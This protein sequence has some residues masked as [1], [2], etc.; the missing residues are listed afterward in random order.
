MI[1]SFAYYAQELS[2]TTQH[3]SLSDRFISGIVL[4]PASYAIEYQTY[5]AQCSYFYDI[6]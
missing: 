6:K 4:D 3:D 5:K 1:I 2:C